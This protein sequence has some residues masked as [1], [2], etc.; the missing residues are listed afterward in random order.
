MASIECVMG[1]LLPLGEPA[2]S[3]ILPQR[4]ES[5]PPAGQELMRIALV[6]YIPNDFIPRGIKD[7]VKG[8]GQFHNA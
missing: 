1:A 8:N 3:V 4:I 2:Y 6:S 5:P 7:V